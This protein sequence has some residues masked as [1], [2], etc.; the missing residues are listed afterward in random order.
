MVLV[1]S[2][3]INKFYCYTYIHNKH[4]IVKYS[5][6]KEIAFYTHFYYSLLQNTNDRHKMCGKCQIKYHYV[7]T[8]RNN[9]NLRGNVRTKLK[10]F[11]QTSCSSISLV[12]V[13]SGFSCRRTFMFC[14]PYYVWVPRCSSVYALKREIRANQE[15]LRAQYYKI[16]WLWLLLV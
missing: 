16:R 6:I 14:R 3:N 2:H 9:G 5:E 11:F 15:K 4:A 1:L 12:I 13:E 8:I 7:L 10:R